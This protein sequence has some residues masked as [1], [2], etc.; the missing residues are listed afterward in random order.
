[1]DL[2]G[3]TALV[4]EDECLV[5]LDVGDTLAE[6]GATVVGIAASCDEALSIIEREQVSAAVLDVNLGEE[7][8]RRVAER[9]AAERIPFVFHTSQTVRDRDRP[10]WMTAPIVSKPC[11]R[12]ELLTAVVAAASRAELSG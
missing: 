3:V 10:A 1:M 11:S 7:T 5:A 12:V 8:S 2:T 4:V 6:A 9:L